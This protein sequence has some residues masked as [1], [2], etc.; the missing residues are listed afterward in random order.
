TGNN[1]YA[2]KGINIGQYKLEIKNPSWF[3]RSYTTQEDA[4]EAYSATATMQVLNEMWK[5]SYNPANPAASWYPQFSGAYLQARAAGADKATALQAARQYADQGRPLPGSPEFQQLFDKARSMPIPKGG[6]FQEKSQLWMTEAQYNLSHLL[7]AVDIVVGGNWKHYIL[8]SKGTI[9][10]DTLNPI[11]NNEW[12]AYAQLTKKLDRVVTLSFSGRYDKNQD[13]AGRFTPRATALLN[14][15]KDQN[16]RLSFQTAYRFPTSTQR[17]IRLDVGSYTILG[18]LPWV[19]DYMKAPL[20]EVDGSTPKP[21]VY[22]ELKPESLRSFEVGY[23]AVIKGKLLVD[24]YTYYGTYSD[25]LG[26]NVVMDAN[27]K[28]Y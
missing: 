3:I 11:S 15:A 2:L 23:K 26:R 16:I 24:A 9:F 4:G 5:P 6:L 22:N 7:P 20:Y 28:I 17:Y 8:N 13:F 10:I 1:R 25:F 19:M 18:G 27:R 14:V 12:G 21:Y